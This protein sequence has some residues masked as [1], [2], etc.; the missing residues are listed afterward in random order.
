MN[1]VESGDTGSPYLLLV[2]Y[3]FIQRRGHQLSWQWSAVQGAY[4]EGLNAGD[5]PAGV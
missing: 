5:R 2:Y 3:A 1:D 4:L